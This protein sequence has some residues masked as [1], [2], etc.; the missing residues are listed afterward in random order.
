MTR[1]LHILTRACTSSDHGGHVAVQLARSDQLVAVNIIAHVGADGGGQTKCH[2]GHTDWFPDSSLLEKQSS[3]MF[4]N[5]ISSTGDGKEA[6]VSQGCA[7][8]FIFLIFTII[9]GVTDFRLFYA[10]KELCSRY[11]TI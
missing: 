1:D 10:L 5:W 4:G 11:I 3:F 9:F 2:R 6:G 8:P 7:E